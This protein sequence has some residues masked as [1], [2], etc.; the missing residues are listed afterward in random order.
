MVLKVELEI[1]RRVE[2]SR[3][4]SVCVPVRLAAAKLVFSVWGHSL[5]KIPALCLTIRAKSMFKGWCAMTRSQTIEGVARRVLL[6]S[7]ESVGG[8]SLCGGDGEA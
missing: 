3:N 2:N 1:R 6:K 7:Q 5:L 8:D 4:E